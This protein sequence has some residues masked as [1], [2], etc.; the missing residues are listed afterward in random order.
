MWPALK[1]FVNELLFDEQAARRKMR[2][3]LQTVAIS[4]VGFANDLGDL[5]H[6][7]DLIAHIKIAAVI[8]GFL[9]GGISVGE[10][11]PPKE[12]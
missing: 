4:G 11:N 12:S 8:A 3:A 10:K 9:A 2:A 6:R 1:T 5:I 7:P